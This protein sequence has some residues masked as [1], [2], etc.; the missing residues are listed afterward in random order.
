MTFL[1]F[2]AKK[3]MKPKRALDLLN[4]GLIKKISFG[5]KEIDRTTYGGIGEGL[6]EISG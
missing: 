6:T 1:K 2:K 3:K 5:C 4:E